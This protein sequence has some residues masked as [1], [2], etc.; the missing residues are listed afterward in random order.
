MTWQ[1]CTGPFGLCTQ[2]DKDRLGYAAIKRLHEKMDDDRDGHVELQETREFMSEELQYGPPG[3][4]A[5]AT[6]ASDQRHHKFHASDM[7]ISLDEMWKSWHYSAV[8][9]WTTDE[10]CAWLHD[11]VQLPQYVDYLRRNQLDG[12]FLPRLALNENN[13]YANVLQIKDQ[14]H[15]RLL[16]I[17]ATDLVLFGQTQSNILEL[18]ISTKNEFE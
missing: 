10:L 11:H 8:Y 3:T 12:Q 17:K 15:K 13:Y 6:A 5:A 16:M 14:R 4:S 9:N 2:E 1:E 7:S 18:L